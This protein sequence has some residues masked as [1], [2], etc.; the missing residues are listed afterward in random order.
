MRKVGPYEVHEITNFD[1]QVS[2]IPPSA[3]QA[4]F[5]FFSAAHGPTSLCHT[6]LDLRHQILGIEKT[7]RC[8]IVRVLGDSRE[9]EVVEIANLKDDVT[10]QQTPFLRC[11]V[12]PN[13]SLFSLKPNEYRIYHSIKSILHAYQ[14]DKAPVHKITKQLNYLQI[15]SGLSFPICYPGGIRGFVFL[16][17]RSEG[18]YTPS[19]KL[20]A[21]ITVLSSLGRS[22]LNGLITPIPNCFSSNFSSDELTLT[23]LES[24]RL[25]KLIGKHLES[26]LDCRPD[27]QI[28]TVIDRPFLI[29]ASNLCNLMTE[30]LIPIIP[31]APPARLSFSFEEVSP[32]TVC[33]RVKELSLW[34]K[35][36]IFSNRGKVHFNRLSTL[37][38][39]L[40]FKIALS[41]KGLEVFFPR[42]DTSPTS[43]VRYS[44][45]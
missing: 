23:T 13:S 9:L 4:L 41:D 3:F 24:E 25:K 2:S 44:T 17:S 16:N 10:D 15:L 12:A 35:T 22:Y 18:A 1:N 29:P 40:G 38:N 27:I 37:A 19:K 36:E 5:P 43:Q 8:C 45:A 6:I 34:F 11:F 31:S 30:V 32:Q 21:T 20:S 33:L 42:T 39:F 28:R 7:D 14:K 26:T